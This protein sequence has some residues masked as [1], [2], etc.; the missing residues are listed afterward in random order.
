MFRH[1][2]VLLKINIRSLSLI[3][4]RFLGTLVESMALL[5]Y[6]IP[7][8]EFKIPPYSTHIHGVQY[9]LK[10]YS[11]GCNLYQIG[12]KYFKHYGASPTIF[13]RTATVVPS[14][15]RLRRLQGP[16]APAPLHPLLR[17]LRFQRE[18]PRHGGR[19]R[20]PLEQKHPNSRCV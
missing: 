6:Y 3:D 18:S 4:I 10:L 14:Q 16:Q 17:V 20:R 2:A 15:Q 1:A 5:Y 19:A 7:I 11:L 12:M 13:L 9:I 8:S